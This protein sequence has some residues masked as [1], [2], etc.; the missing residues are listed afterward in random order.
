MLLYLDAGD[1]L[2]KSQ[3]MDSAHTPFS[4]PQVYQGLATGGGLATATNAGLT[5]EFQV[6]DGFFGVIKSGIQRVVIPLGDLHS[7]DLKQGWFGNRLIIKVRSI[8]TLESVPGSDTGQVELKVARRDRTTAEALVSILML[9]LSE[10]K[11][12]DLGRQGLST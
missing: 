3:T 1:L 6:K 11:L 2:S 5:L 7:V 10:K 8:A 4:F 9:S 12:A